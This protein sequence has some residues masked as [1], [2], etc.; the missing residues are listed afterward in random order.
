MTGQ[1]GADRWADTRQLL[2]ELEQLDPEGYELAETEELA[3][4]RI[5]EEDFQVE[6][7]EDYRSFLLEVS[8][9]APGPIDFC[10]SIDETLEVIAEGIAEEDEEAD[11]DTIDASWLSE[12]FPAPKTL[13]ESRELSG[14]CP[15]TWPIAELSEGMFVAVV[16]SGPER[17]NLWAGGDLWYPL[18]LPTQPE[19]EPDGDDEAAFER[20][21]AA[22]L[23]SSARVQFAAWYGAWAAAELAELR[24]A[25]AVSSAN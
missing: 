4:V 9:A 16:V 19:S 7:P 25:G 6:F 18:H 10:W 12:E 13:A 23:A 3:E 2:R 24:E 5:V 17:G 21:V 1:S 14:V 20:W 8:A 15:G 11:P 22:R